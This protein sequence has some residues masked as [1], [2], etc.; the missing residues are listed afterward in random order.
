[1]KKPYMCTIIGS[2]GRDCVLSYFNFMALR[3]G[4]LKVLYSGWLNMTPLNLHSRRRT[5]PILIQLNTI[6]KQP[7]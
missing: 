3:L 2:S 6:L 7:I 5:N 1:M 4:F